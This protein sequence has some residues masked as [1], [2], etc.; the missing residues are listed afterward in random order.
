[1][2]FLLTDDNDITLEIEKLMLE[3]CGLSVVTACS[4]EE[5]VKLADENDFF[6]IFMD[7]NMP[8]MNG[9]QTSE[10][11][12]QKNKDVPI[13]AL[14][15]DKIDGSNED[16]IKSGMNGAL[17]KPLDPDDLKKLLGKYIV[18]DIA[19]KNDEEIDDSLFAY[20]E[21]L[22]VMKDEKAVCRLLT[23]FLTIHD[24]DC[25][26]LKEHIKNNE[27]FRARE[28]M[29]NII[30]ISGNMFCKRLYRISCA[31]SG[32]LKQGSSDSLESFTEI[33]N[34]TFKELSEC[35]E[36]LSDSEETVEKDVDWNELKKNFNRLCADFDVYASDVFSENIS[37]FMK[38]MT[39]ENFNKLKNA[40][41]NYDFPWIID[42]SEVLYV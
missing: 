34:D 29:H 15:A 21:L 13:I 42:N 30:G 1:M 33:W 10:V 25:N 41:L 11:I 32:E 5:A 18:I 16:Y 40:I 27:I 24:D 2:E 17:L 9:F 38:N 8:G 19:E 20:D 7:I 35:R 6:M 39:R 23:K 31:L 28:I 36:K 4:G 37:V 12:R 14:S 26:A 3:S 22:A